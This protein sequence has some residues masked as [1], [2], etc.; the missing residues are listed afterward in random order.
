MTFAENLTATMK[1]LLNGMHDDGY[2][3]G[4]EAG[5]AEGGGIDIFQYVKRV[6][7]MFY[8]GD[9]GKETKLSVSLPNIDVGTN[10]IVNLAD[11]F[12]L[13]RGLVELTLDLPTDKKYNLTAFAYDNSTKYSSLEKIVFKNP[14]KVTNF[15]NF[16]VYNQQLTTVEGK[17]DLSESETNDG[18]YS[19]CPALVKVEFVPETI[20]KSISFAQSTKLS[21]ASITSIMYGLSKNGSGQTVTLSKA[22]VD[23]AFAEYSPETG[24]FIAPGSVS[25]E[26]VTIVSYV[27]DELGWTVTLI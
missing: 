12:R 21:Y 15:N 3:K 5:K 17:V 20:K 18:C 25:A 27:T 10:G 26:W 6:N 8:R 2:S 13:C 16:A 7:Q 11:M 4:F 14:V 9:F 24:E 19:N 23:T 1:P 22:A